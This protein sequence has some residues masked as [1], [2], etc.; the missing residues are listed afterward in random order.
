[1]LKVGITG[2]IGSGKTYVCKLFAEKGVP[3]Y[4]AD[5]RARFI[6][7]HD[8]SV[9]EQIVQL[10]GEH[11]YRN[12]ELNRTFIAE[13]VFKDKAKLE[14]LNA[15]VHPAVGK[16]YEVWLSEHQHEPYTLKEAAIMIETRGYKLLDYLILVTAPKE[17][18]INRIKERDSLTQEDIIARMDKQMDDAEKI[19]FADFVIENNGDDSL[20]DKVNTLHEQLISLSK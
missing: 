13:Q 15:I 10:F 4:N 2:G 19:K 7:N 5:L 20:A 8:V 6:M 17:I 9:K 1:M 12:E 3:V 11:A 14:Q 16:D 18:R